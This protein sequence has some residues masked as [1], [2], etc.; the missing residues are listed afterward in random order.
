MPNVVP[1]FIH[2]LTVVGGGGE[3]PDTHL[4]ARCQQELPAGEYLPPPD[5]E[6]QSEFDLAYQTSLHRSST[7]TRKRKSSRSKVVKTVSTGL[8]A[9]VLSPIVV[10]GAALAAS[11]FILYGTGKV[12]EG[13]GRSIAAGPEAVY[14]MCNKTKRAGRIRRAFEK[15][16]SSKEETEA[17]DDHPV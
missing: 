8:L 6:H 7:R 4:P 9:L 10:A 12:L 15:S 13:V 14:E 5:P 3:T 16:S 1:T 17:H 2:C 11:S